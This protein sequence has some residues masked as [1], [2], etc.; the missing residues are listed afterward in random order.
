MPGTKGEPGLPGAI[1][2]TEQNYTGLPNWK[3]CTWTS[4]DHRNFGL[5]K[6]CIFYKYSNESILH[7]P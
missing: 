6:V 3:Q 1:V 2:P 5:I 7:V 4:G